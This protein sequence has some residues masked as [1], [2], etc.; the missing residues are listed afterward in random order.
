MCTVPTLTLGNI[1][2]RLLFG[3]SVQALDV[4]GGLAVS[5]D[6]AGHLK[7][8]DVS[9]PANPIVLGDLATGYPIMRVRLID[10]VAY[11]VYDQKDGVAFDMVDLSVPAHPAIVVTAWDLYRP[12]SFNVGTYCVD[13]IGDY[14]F[15]PPNEYF[16]D[17]SYAVQVSGGWGGLVMYLSDPKLDIVFPWGA[18]RNMVRWYPA[19]YVHGIWDKFIDIV[20][21]KNSRYLY[22]MTD[23]TLLILDPFGGNILSEW[24]EIG[25]IDLSSIEHA[26]LLKL[27]DGYAYVTTNNGVWIISLARLGTPDFGSDNDGDGK[28]DDIIGNFETRGPA[29]DMAIANGMAYV[30]DKDN[31][32]ISVVD[33]S[34]PHAPAEIGVIGTDGEPLT[35]KA[36][37]NTLYVGDSKGISV[38]EIEP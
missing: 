16:T 20:V 11:V 6:L 1:T 35:V 21:D 4:G 38:I 17:A 2:T 15:S 31:G 14:S 30:T 22:A 7:T 18:L 34:D 10:N 23:S 13:G 33:I 9:N 28:P 32:G 24:G 19:W 36:V 26:K 37:G 12:G 27:I 8:Y 3:N 5:G 29:Y 25:L